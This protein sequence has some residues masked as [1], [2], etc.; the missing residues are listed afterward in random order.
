METILTWLNRAVEGAPAVSLT[1]ALVWGVLSVVCSPCHLAS[2]PLIVGYIN[3]QGRMSARRATAVSSMFAA[4]ILVTI[5]II[6]VI[7]HFIGQIIGDIGPYGTYI[8]AGVFFLVGLHLL[9]VIPLPLS[10]PG[11]VN[12]KRRGLLGGFLLGLIFGVALGPCTFGYLMPVLVVST[13]LSSDRPV[14]AGALLLAYGLGHCIVI[15]LAGALTG[16]V[17]RWLDWN[18]RSRGAMILRRICGLAVLGGG[19][20]LVYKA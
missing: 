14:Q 10:G 11:H 6:G 20:Y 5:A 1:A 3:G 7:T 8:V 19:S 12:M 4:G 18:R 13:K 17:Q 2:I 15:A 9:D 16:L